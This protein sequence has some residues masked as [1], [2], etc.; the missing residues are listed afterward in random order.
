M[1]HLY[2]R[3]DSMLLIDIFIVLRDIENF[4]YNTYKDFINV[5]CREIPHPGVSIK[6]LVKVAYGFQTRPNDNMIHVEIDMIVY[7]RFQ[8]LREALQQTINSEE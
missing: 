2:L 5:V 6:D 3:A 1:I 8:F 7:Q 4:S